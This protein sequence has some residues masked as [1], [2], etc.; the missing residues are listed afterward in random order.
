MNI[1]KLQDYDLVITCSVNSHGDTFTGHIFE[2]LDYYLILKNYYNI[3]VVL[4][5]DFLKYNFE[6]ILKR[7]T[8]NINLN[9]IVF[10]KYDYIFAN[11]ILNCD[12][13]YYNFNR[14]IAPKIFSFS[15]CFGYFQKEKDR[16]KNVIFLADS[17]IY[18]NS[19]QID[20]VKKILPDIKAEKCNNRSFAHLTG[21]IRELDKDQFN[22]LL[23]KY[24]NILCYSETFQNS[25]NTTN[26]GLY[27]FEFSKYIYTPIKRHFDCSP[28]LIIES[29]I[30]GKEVDY[31]EIDYNDIGLERRRFGNLDEFILD[32][33]DDIIKILR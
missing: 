17:K 15:C 20:Y 8:L 6:K 23:L 18:Q 9:D 31:F 28:R 33:N 3:K 24:P 10:C 27:N 12:D 11:K 19:N 7:Y 22:R 26:I 32:T 21:S 14:L 5:F 16:P 25:Y 1:L 29:Q 30:L 2:C 13:N 4:P